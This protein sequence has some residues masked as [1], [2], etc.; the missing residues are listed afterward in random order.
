MPGPTLPWLARIADWLTMRNTWRM[1]V[2][3]ACDCTATEAKF[4]G[5]YLRARTR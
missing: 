3:V 5:R 2:G 4:F 1:A